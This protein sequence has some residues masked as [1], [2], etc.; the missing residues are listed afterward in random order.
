[1]DILKPNWPV[2]AQVK[3]I[4]T[5]RTGGRSKPPYHSNNLAL[6]VGDDLTHVTQNRQSLTTLVGA[7]PAWLKQEHTSEIIELPPSADHSLIADAC[8]TRAACTPCAIQTADCLPVLICNKRGTEIAAVHAGWRGLAAGILAASLARFSC[9]AIDLMVYL[10]PAISKEH[11]EVG[12]DVRQAFV[13]AQRSR[14]FSEP[15]SAAFQPHPLTDGK[16]YADMYRLAR[17]ELSAAGVNAIYGGEYCTYTQADKFFS[18]RRDGV[19]GRM[20]SAIWLS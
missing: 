5:L 1:M 4:V 13:Q 10:G 14:D 3:A 7:E 12:D 18:Y 8:Y 2:P 17:A 16:Y 15:V 11:F 19:T 6:H 20:L 9:P